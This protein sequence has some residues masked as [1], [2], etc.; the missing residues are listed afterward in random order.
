MESQI[1]STRPFLL[2]KSDDPITW[3]EEELLKRATPIY[4]TPELSLYELSPDSL[5]ANTAKREIAAFETKRPMLK[6]KDG[7]LVT[8]TAAFIYYNSYD[9]ISSPHT[10]RGKGG[11]SGNK[12]DYLFLA[13]MPGKNFDLKQTYVASFWM[14]NCG[15]NYGQDMLNSLVVVQTKIGNNAEWISYAGAENTIIVDGCWSYVEIPFMLDKP[16]DNVSILVKGADYS[17]LQSYFDELLI[18]PANVDVYRVLAQHGDTITTLFKNNQQI[19][20]DASKWNRNKNSTK[21]YEQKN[22]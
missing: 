18:R 11:F 14:Y 21:Y 5:F 10:F 6:Q 3:Y 1:T 20:I 2:V 9:T 19:K 12:K 17:K 22:L 15:K 4:L 16:V 8:D 13:E 7:F